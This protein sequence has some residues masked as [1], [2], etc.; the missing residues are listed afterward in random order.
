MRALAL[1]PALIAGPKLPH[2]STVCIAPANSLRRVSEGSPSVPFPSPCPCPHPKFTRMPSSLQL[3]DVSVHPHARR[4]VVAATAPTATAAETAAPK[5]KRTTTAQ[6][7]S[8]V[9]ELEAE[10]AALRAAL[11]AALGSE[12]AAAAVAAEVE[13]P[14]ATSP[15]PPASSSSSSSLESGIRW[16][17]PGESPPF[18]ERPAREAPAPPVAEGA[19]P[20]APPPPPAR[21]LSVVHITAEMAPCA[22][23][24]GLGD[25]VTGL[26]KAL[27]AQGHAPEV[28]LPFYEC[29]PDSAVEDLTFERAF[30][31]PKG[32]SGAALRTLAFTG[33]IDGVRVALLR[34]D[35][36]ATGSP[37]FRG[38]RIYGGSYNEVEAYLYFCRAALELLVV[39]GRRPDVVHAHEWQTSA[40]PMLFWELY[41]SALPGARP[42]LTIHNMGNPGE[43]RQDEFDATGVPGEAFADVNK[44]LDERTIGHNPERLCLLKGGIVYAS[45]VTTVSPTYAAETLTGGAAGWLQSTLA[46]PEVAAKYWGVL[47]GIDTQAWDPAADPDLPAP[48][49]AAAPAGKALCKAYLQRGLGMTVDPSKPLVAVISRLVPQKGINLIE[50]AV[51]RTAGA[52]GQFVLLGTGHADAGLRNLANNVHGDNPDVAMVFGYSETLAHLIYAAADLFLVPSMFEPC[53]LTQMIALRYGVVPVVRATGGL[54]D[55]VRDVDAGRN[56]GDESALGS[57]PPPNGFVFDGVDAGSLDGALNRAFGMY[58]TRPAEW[59]ALRDRNLAEG[60]RWS[61]DASAASYVALYTGVMAS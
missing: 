7:K 4:R 52:G 21:P 15:P 57:A 26:S 59:A 11:A 33:S 50:H 30:D 9:D 56:G 51:G 14:P 10:N 31:V 27:A 45:V 49:S 44:A 38:G 48:F 2:G 40:V 61:W 1:T 39:S 16:P 58:H 17:T 37:L 41:A 18:W 32:T 47:N 3:S 8:R 22:K 20:S 46:R 28:V 36:E 19:P 29:L 35:W 60:Q 54:A 34:P 42:A 5:A 6:L 12:H 13:A 23:V 53:G 43:C 25:V 24:G 55:T